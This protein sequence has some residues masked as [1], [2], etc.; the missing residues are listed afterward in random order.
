MQLSI[1]QIEDL[2]LRQ[3]AFAL[4]GHEVIRKQIEVRNVHRL[5]IRNHLGPI[6]LLWIGDGRAD[7]AEVDSGI[8]RPNVEA[9][10]AVIDE[11]FQV[12]L[13]RHDHARSGSGIVRWDRAHFAARLT[14]RSREN[15]VAAE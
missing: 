6:L 5:A 9:I 4:G 7:D 3:A 1:A 15:P 10:A 11:V 12:L 14:L 13:A 8:V 2:E